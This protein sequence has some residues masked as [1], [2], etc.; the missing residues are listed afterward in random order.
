M[1]WGVL[2]SAIISVLTCGGVV[3]W[4]NPKAAKKK[5]ELE[6][7]ATEAQTMQTQTQAYN[8]A[9]QSMQETIKSQEDRNRELFEL[10]VKA[11]DEINSL[12]S[13]LAQCAT[14]LCRNS[15][16]PLRVPERGL[17][18]E[19]L[20]DCRAKRISLFDNTEFD[21]IATN[22]GYSVKKIKKIITE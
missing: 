1:D 22:K 3:W 12:K 2:I 9:M 19:L 13:D 21:E 4:V 8:Q 6:N 14:A 16:C 10:N 20:E 5:P 17:G 18:D 7:N 11:H 15:M